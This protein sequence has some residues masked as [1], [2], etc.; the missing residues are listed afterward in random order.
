VRLQSRSRQ[1]VCDIGDSS[2]VFVVARGAMFNGV[3]CEQICSEVQV[4]NTEPSAAE[5]V[6]A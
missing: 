4:C 5:R 1:K 6:A 2:R 3:D